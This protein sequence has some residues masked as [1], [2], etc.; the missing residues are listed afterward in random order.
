MEESKN[1]LEPINIGWHLQGQT[2]KPVS[3]LACFSDFDGVSVLQ[4]SGSIVIILNI[5]IWLSS[6]RS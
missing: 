3:V 6:R 4:K 5:H 2:I 1:K